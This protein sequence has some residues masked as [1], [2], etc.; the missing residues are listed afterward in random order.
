MH[1]TACRLGYLHRFRGGPGQNNMAHGTVTLG[2]FCISVPVAYVKG[3]T[4]QEIAV[5]SVNREQLQQV[6]LDLEMYTRVSYLE[7]E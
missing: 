1:H 5:T 3:F 7:G 6:Y 2:F 4:G